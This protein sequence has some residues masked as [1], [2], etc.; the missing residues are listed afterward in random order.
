MNLS[1]TK[2]AV[3]ALAT[4]GLAAAGI[5]IAATRGD[6]GTCASLDREL[7]RIESKF[8]DEPT[9]SW[10]DIYTLNGVGADRDR[11]LRERAANDCD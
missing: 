6:G 10:D 1:P 2:K 7:A 9:Q 11:V 8:S 5:A 4:V 3:L